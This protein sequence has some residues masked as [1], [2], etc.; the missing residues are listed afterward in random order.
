MDCELFETVLKYDVFKWD[1]T[2]LNPRDYLVKAQQLLP[3]E[4]EEKTMT[5]AESFVAVGKEMGQKEGVEQAVQ[6]ISLLNKNTAPEEIA[7]ITA[8]DID[9]IFALKNQLGF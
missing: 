3:H 1:E 5:F 2:V 6:A 9:S 4:L 8:L 7:R